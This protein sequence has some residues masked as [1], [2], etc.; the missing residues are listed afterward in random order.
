MPAHRSQCVDIAKCIDNT[1]T[2]EHANFMSPQNSV[3]VL[4]DGCTKRRITLNILLSKVYLE[5]NVVH[6]V[7]KQHTNCE[8]LMKKTEFYYSTETPRS[9]FGEGNLLQTRSLHLT[10]LCAFTTAP[11]ITGL[12]TRLSPGSRHDQTRS[13]ES[14]SRHRHIFR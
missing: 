2:E 13:S 11:F 6:L 3:L 7:D 8:K 10:L 9:Y 1:T 14:C 5:T 4:M 12:S